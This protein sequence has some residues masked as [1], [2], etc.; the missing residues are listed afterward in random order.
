MEM[1]RWMNKDMIEASKKK[2]KV[3]NAALGLLKKN[4]LN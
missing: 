3:F 4:W 1:L 2:K